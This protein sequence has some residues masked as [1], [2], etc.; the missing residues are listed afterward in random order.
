MNKRGGRGRGVRE[1]KNL[2]ATHMKAQKLVQ[3]FE[4]SFK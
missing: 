4:S 3:G 2:S 1:F